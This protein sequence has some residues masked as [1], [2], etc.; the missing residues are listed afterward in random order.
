MPRL[1]SFRRLA[2]QHHSAVICDREPLGEKAKVQLSKTEELS[3]PQGPFAHTSTNDNHHAAIG[4]AHSKLILIGEHAV[5]HGKPAI[6]LPFPMVGVEAVAEAV[7]GPLSIDCDFY[8]GPLATAP[9]ALRGI[10]EC[11]VGTLKRLGNMTEGLL[12]RL[13]S[14]IPPGRGLGSSAAVAVAAVRSIFAYYDREATHS[15]IIALANIAEVYAHG[16]PSGIDA[17][18]AAADGPM[19][20]IKGQEPES[21]PTGAV[22]E[23][24]VADSGRIGD[25]RSAVSAVHERLAS[26]PEETK[27]RLHRLGSL[28]RE[29]RQALAEGDAE[30]L[31][32]IMNRAQEELSA[33]GVSDSG[34]NR[35]VRAACKAGALGAKLTGG[36]RGGC[37]LAL[38]RDAYH[39]EQ[40]CSAL[41]RAGARAIWRHTLGEVQEC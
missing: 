25:T 4:H 40:L 13:A 27:G 37:I 34:L 17:L 24:V 29:A 15:E 7:P 30:Q 9:E 5:V 28:A 22:F 1:S 26:K 38:A 18:A 23:L 11:I 19:W 6:A 3:E 32:Q 8:H 10:A 35:L 20:F 39:A 41:A 12:I 14:T 2:L 21:L 31:G 16:T 36:G 33:L